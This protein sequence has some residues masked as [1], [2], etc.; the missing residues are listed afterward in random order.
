[1]ADNLI[2]LIENSTCLIWAL[3]ASVIIA[4]VALGIAIYISY[5]KRPDF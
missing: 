2:K 1:M 3:R 4:L 5:N